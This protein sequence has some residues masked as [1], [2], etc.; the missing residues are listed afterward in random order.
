M[1]KDK[2]IVGGPATAAGLL[3]QFREK[4]EE[5]Y[6]EGK[7]KE[8]EKEESSEKWDYSQVPEK[9]WEYDHWDISDGICYASISVSPEGVSWGLFN[10]TNNVASWGG[11]GGRTLSFEDFD[12]MLDENANT[13]L[14]TLKEV[15]DYIALHQKKR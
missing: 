8:P 3:G 2:N 1:K 15:R 13:P 4:I 7:Y 9:E 14:E 12:A 10:D 6:F 5:G 11:H